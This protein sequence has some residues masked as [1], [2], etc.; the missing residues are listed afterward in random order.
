MTRI[1]IVRGHQATPWELAPWRE[2]PPRFEVS[3]LRTGATPH[4]AAAIGLDAVP[5]GAV[6]DR[7]PAGRLRD[8]VIGLAGD[9]YGA[10]ADAAFAAADIVHAEELSYWFAAD[11]ARRRA[12]GGAFRLVQT[13]W[14]TLP[15]LT[16]Y[17]NAR[18]RRHR[19][20]VLLGTDLFLPATERAAMAL[21]LEGVAPERIEVCSPGIDVGRFSVA[22]PEAAAAHTILSP[23]RLVWEKGHH[24]VL[25]A[26]ALLHRGIVPLPDGS[27]ARP[28]LRIVGQGPEEGRLRAYAR[29]LGLE[30]FVSFESVVYGDMPQTFASASV[31]LLGSQSSA[32]MARHPFDVPHAFWEEQFGMVFAEAMAAGLDIVATTNG[33]I[34][35]VLAGQG[36]LV[37]AG[38]YVAMARALAAGALARPPAVR[39]AYPPTLVE[40]YSTTAMA[41]RLATVYDRL[42]AE[43]AAT[44][45][46]R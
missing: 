15:F 36:T 20:E 3:Y 11:A 33:A 2:M 31:L 29:E 43:P 25:R 45:R 35:E 32:T 27:T 30:A 40:H 37:A 46:R 38:D 18:S 41:R 5:V 14:E 22:Q 1:L 34:P 4:D 6:R 28:R 26:V 19:E 42:L 7:V 9:R 17:R 10:D 44:S 8:V 16:T 21:R 23:G 24:D 39:V 12:A 13:A